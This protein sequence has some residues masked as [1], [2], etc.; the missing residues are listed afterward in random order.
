[1][2][3]LTGTSFARLIILFSTLQPMSTGKMNLYDDWRIEISFSSSV[4]DGCSH[5]L[6]PLK[7]SW[8]LVGVVWLLAILAPACMH[9]IIENL[10]FKHSHWILNLSFS[11]LGVCVMCELSIRELRVWTSCTAYIQTDP[12]QARSW[13]LENILK[14]GHEVREGMK[15]L[16]PNILTPNK[17]II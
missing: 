6:C 7:E 16:D 5:V 1:M 2:Y 8:V 14:K 12:H 17:F 10:F 4:T 11:V 9:I 15:I 3:I 13:P